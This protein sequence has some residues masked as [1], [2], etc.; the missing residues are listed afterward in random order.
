MQQEGHAIGAQADI[1]F[2]HA[3]AV[4][5]TEALTAE[6]EAAKP[7]KPAARR[8]TRKPADATGEGN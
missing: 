5:V 4:G 6:A 3:I 2:E 1:A 8:R 7:R